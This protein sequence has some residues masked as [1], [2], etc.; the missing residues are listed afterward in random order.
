MVPALAVAGAFASGTTVIKGA[1]RL[2][3]KESD[4]IE[5]VCS[6]LKQLGAD[7]TQTEDGMIIRSK[8]LHCAQLKGFN[9]HRIVM[10]MSVC[11]SGLDGVTIIDDAQSIDKS[12]PD[13]F[14]DFNSIGGNANVLCDR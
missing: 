8:T 5:S 1:S 2:R 4:R 10:S 14:D 7:V 6:N 12:Y 13:F 3:F 9:D 11:A